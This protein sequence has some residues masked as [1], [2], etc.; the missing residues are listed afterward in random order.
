[1]RDD[2]GGV[3]VMEAHAPRHPGDL[4][5]C[6]FSDRPRPRP[7]R[8]VAGVREPKKHVRINRPY[9]VSHDGTGYF[10]GDTAA[11]PQSLAD[12]WIR[13]RWASPIGKGDQ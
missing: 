5:P 2:D 13:S 7:A 8:S 9:H 3:W 6:E 10:P 4:G 11:V 12:E 1:M